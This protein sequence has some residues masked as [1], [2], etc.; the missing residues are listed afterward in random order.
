VP[1][2]K[3]V[4]TGLSIASFETLI[5]CPL[6][7]LKVWSITYRGHDGKARKFRNFFSACRVSYPSLERNG[8]AFPATGELFR[9]IHAV[10][11]RQ[12]TSWVVFLTT[13]SSARNAARHITGSEQL[14]F[15]TLL[16]VSSMVGG[17]NTAAVMPIDCV[18]THFQRRNQPLDSRC[19]LR[20]ALQEAVVK[21]GLRGLYAGWPARLA[22][23][24]LSA[25][26]TVPLLEVL[27][28]NRCFSSNCKIA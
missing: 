9:G 13:E 14:G 16:A 15:G 5:I 7:R 22:Q 20:G 4:L 6:E 24:I 17:I 19:S 1:A 23:Y 12:I 10:L 2:V 26:I 8:V 27:E 25:A 3:P 11:A 28:R 21:H 18:K